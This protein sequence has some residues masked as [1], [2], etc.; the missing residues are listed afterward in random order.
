MPLIFVQAVVS[1]MFH[2]CT[3]ASMFWGYVSGLYYTVNLTDMG[4][5][6][7]YYNWL[8]INVGKV[9]YNII[10]PLSL[11][12]NH[13]SV[14]HD[15]TCVM[16]RLYYWGNFIWDLPWLIWLHTIYILSWWLWY[17]D[18]QVQEERRKVSM[19][20]DIWYGFS[21]QKLLYCPWCKKQ[22]CLYRADQYVAKQKGSQA[23]IHI[24][25]W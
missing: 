25:S 14:N 16:A 7:W 3:Q 21:D 18:K 11:Q 6:S 17:E 23:D 13:W 20:T 10:R 1:R 9:K 2:A 4:L 12:F 8:I 24:W 15:V 19:F 22:T 5:K